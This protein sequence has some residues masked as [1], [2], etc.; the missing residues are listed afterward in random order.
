MEDL[1]YGDMSDFKHEGYGDDNVLVDYL[2]KRERRK[3]E[4]Q[5]VYSEEW[6]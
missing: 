2:L 3:L 6:K 5:P 1:D 4:T